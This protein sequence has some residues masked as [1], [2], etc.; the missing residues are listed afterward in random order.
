MKT[1]VDAMP[2]RR[3]RTERMAARGTA[4]V[5]RTDWNMIRYP[6]MP[7]TAVPKIRRKPFEMVVSTCMRS[8]MVKSFGGQDQLKHDRVPNDAANSSSKNPQEAL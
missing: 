8:H 4:L 2:A 3:S 6:T 5:A 1:L 7:P